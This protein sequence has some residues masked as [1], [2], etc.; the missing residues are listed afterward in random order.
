MAC[1]SGYCHWEDLGL[2]QCSSAT[3]IVVELLVSNSLSLSQTQFAP[4]QNGVAVRID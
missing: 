2:N 4:M 1:E 3:Y